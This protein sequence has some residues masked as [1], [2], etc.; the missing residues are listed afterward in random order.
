[1]QGRRDGRRGARQRGRELAE[2]DLVVP[3]YFATCNECAR[4]G[5]GQHQ[6]CENA[7]KYW[8]RAPDEW[9]HFHGTFASHYYVHHDQYVYKVP[10]D[11]DEDGCR[12][13]ELRPRRCS[14]ASTLSEATQGDTVVVQGAG[15]LGLNAT[16]VATERGAETIVVDGVADRLDR[17]GRSAPTTPST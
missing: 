16:A 7:Y 13:G 17:A 3:A 9:P 12:R 6:Y 15:G 10:A 11:V 1:V 5:R 14:T 8:S 2:G 4:C